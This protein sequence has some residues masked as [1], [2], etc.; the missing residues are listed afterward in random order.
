MILERLDGF[1][2]SVASVVVWGHKLVS[3]FVGFYRFLELVG[4]LVIEDVF[5]RE[6]ATFVQAIHK[7][8]ICSRHFSCGSVFHG[9]DEYCRAVTFD[10][11]HDVLISTT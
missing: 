3:H 11:D 1:F 9:L 10:E 7:S 8:L 6:D 2:C 4:A 5:L